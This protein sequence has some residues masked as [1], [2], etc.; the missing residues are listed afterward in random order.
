MS[1]CNVD[2][3]ARCSSVQLMNYVPLVPEQS[4][5]SHRAHLVLQVVSQVQV[6]GRVW[7]VQQ[8]QV[9]WIHQVDA[10]LQDLLHWTLRDRIRKLRVLQKHNVGQN[11]RDVVA[12]L[13][14][15][16]SSHERRSEQ[17]KWRQTSEGPEAELL[18]LMREPVNMQNNPGPE[19]VPPLRPHLVRGLLYL[20]S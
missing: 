15:T 3:P 4:C 2:S 19:P 9:A 11:L 17:K 16:W 6:L 10:E 12:T 14:P 13:K 1:L 18:A 20:L 8:L 7:T 5:S